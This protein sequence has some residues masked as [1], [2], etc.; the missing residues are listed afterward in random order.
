MPPVNNPNLVSLTSIN[1]DGSRNFLHPADVRGNFTVWRRVFGAVLLAIYILLPWIPIGGYPAVFL[2]LA[3]RRFHFFGLTFLAED[4]WIGFFLFSGLGFS[5]FYVTALFGRLWCGWACPYT[6]F[7]EHLYRRVE[8]WIEGDAVRRRRLDAAPW[9]RTKIIKRVFK[10]AIYIL[11]SLI[12]A[13]IFVSYF[14]S[15]PRLY[16]YMQQ[17]PA[18]NVKSFGVMLFLTVCLYGSFAWF[19]E[20]FC[21]ILCPYGRIQSALTDDDTIIIGYDEKRGEP[22]GKRSNPESGSCIACNRCVQVCPTGIDIR[23]G[24]QL[25]CIGCANCIDA[26]NEIMDKTKQPRGLVRYDSLNGLQGKE[27]R[28]WRPR[29]ALYTGFLFLGLAVAGTVVSGLQPAKIEIIRMAGQPYYF[30]E[31]GVRNQYRVQLITKQSVPALLTFRFPGLPEGAL[32]SGLPDK[33]TLEPSVETM[34]TVLVQ[35]P[36]ENYTGEFKFTIEA[37]VTPGDFT[38]TDTIDFFGPSPYTLNQSKP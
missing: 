22:R 5:L 25:E 8:R 16:E 12:L 1:R 28:I 3:E 15:I 9:H 14:V 17:S 27:R 33:I 32:V 6:V 4:L 36:K 10:H 26:C 24:L 7:L 18:N 35:V 20:Q 29:V 38:L 13:H 11:I 2:D 30:G 34:Q 23:N 31:E 19:R 21:I 37:D